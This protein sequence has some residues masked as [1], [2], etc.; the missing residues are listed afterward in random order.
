MDDTKA[1]ARLPGLD[2]ELK[3]RV[4]AEEG[5]EYVSV[6]LRGIPSL[7]AFGAALQPT[8]LTSLASLPFSLWQSWFDMAQAFWRPF[9]PQGSD[10]PRLPKEP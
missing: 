8:A 1:T 5:S 2:I 4:D 3:R 9:L 7:G 10:R 6:S